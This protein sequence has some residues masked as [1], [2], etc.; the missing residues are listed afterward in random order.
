MDSDGLIYEPIKEKADSLAMLIINILD[1]N[2]YEKYNRF[3]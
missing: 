1:F 2:Q 3:T